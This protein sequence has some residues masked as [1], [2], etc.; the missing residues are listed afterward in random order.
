MPHAAKEVMQSGSRVHVASKPLPPY[1]RQPGRRG[2]G[3]VPGAE[4]VKRMKG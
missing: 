3:T 2:S 1:K 4:T